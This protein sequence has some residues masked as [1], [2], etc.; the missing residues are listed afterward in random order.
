MEAFHVEK[1]LNT[2]ERIVSIS[3]TIHSDEF[4]KIKGRL[5]WGAQTSEKILKNS[6]EKDRIEEQ[7]K[8]FFIHKSFTKKDYIKALEKDGYPVELIGRDEYL[9][10]LA[11][12]PNAPQDAE[13]IKKISEANAYLEK[14]SS[15]T[16]RSLTNDFAWTNEFRALKQ[17]R[18]QSKSGNS[19]PSSNATHSA[20][21]PPMITEAKQPVQLPPDNILPGNILKKEMAPRHDSSPAP[22]PWIVGGLVVFGIIGTIAFKLLRHSKG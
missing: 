19:T 5:M 17:S 4:S 2:L 6:T 1:A 22:W 11:L 21:S 20:S 15:Y 18:K 16:A 3:D 7:H 14:L 12:P 9:A 13:T 10:L 8:R